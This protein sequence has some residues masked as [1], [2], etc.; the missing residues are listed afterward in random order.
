[1]QRGSSPF[2]CTDV[3]HWVDCC[4]DPG[5]ASGHPYEGTTECGDRAG[6]RFFKKSLL[7]VRAHDVHAGAL[8][9]WQGLKTTLRNRFSSP[10]LGVQ[11]LNSGVRACFTIRPSC[12][13]LRCTNARSVKG[14]NK[15][16]LFNI[17]NSLYC[18]DHTDKN[19]TRLD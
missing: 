19:V 2:P 8:V 6:R 16:Q 1:M 7:Y 17:R 11:G 15:N 5:L 14:I 12:S 10:T 9:P 3:Y 4:V 18:N 13:A